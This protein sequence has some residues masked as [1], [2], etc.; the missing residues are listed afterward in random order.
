METN[1]NL[2][3]PKV[4]A[5]LID[6]TIL[7]PE[8][9]VEE[10]LQYCQDAVKFGFASVCVN[11]SFVAL[12]HGALR[13]SGVKTC[14]V[15]GFPLG[16]TTSSVKYAEAR[17]ALYDGAEELD[18][19]INVGYLKSGDLGYVRQEIETLSRIAHGEGALLKVDRK[20]VV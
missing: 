6:H 19:V 1:L 9:S 10:V 14:T 15:I 17:R 13:A 11:P 12:A 18:M 3:D 8:A 16:A 4:V 2:N 5:S 20:S 7:K